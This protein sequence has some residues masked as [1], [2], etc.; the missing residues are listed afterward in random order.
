MVQT[1]VG[2][3]DV[4]KALTHRPSLMENC[5]QAQQGPLMPG[6]QPQ[7]GRSQQICGAQWHHDSAYAN[8]QMFVRQ[9]SR[10]APASGGYG[11]CGQ[12]IMKATAAPA[13]ALKLLHYPLPSA[14]I[15]LCK[16]PMS[17]RLVPSNCPVGV[18]SRISPLEKLAQSEPEHCFMIQTP[19]GSAAFDTMPST[20]LEDL[21]SNGQNVLW[22]PSNAAEAARHAP[23]G[24]YV[25][26]VYC[27]S[28][29]DV[30][31]LPLPTMRR[32]EITPG[33]Q[34]MHLMDPGLRPLQE[35]NR[36]PQVQGPASKYMAT[37]DMSSTD[38]CRSNESTSASGGSGQI[39]GSI[40]H[41]ALPKA[42]LG[43]PELPSRG[44]ALHAWKACKPCAFVFQE[45][46]ANNEECEFC[47]LCEPGERKRRK[48]ER[49][50]ERRDV[51]Q[52]AAGGLRNQQFTQLG[53][54]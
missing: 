23:S 37:Q 8:N 48:K 54:R 3:M 6:A 47:H 16:A 9:N 26:N 30:P 13:A 12:R 39:E 40:D 28:R 34:S 5:Y 44:S 18:L 51:R 33:Q 45:G 10:F 43:S 49:K 1:C 29:N 14:P 20:P 53:M 52:T 41:Q 4:S 11:Y 35:Y 7:L 25:A 2:P 38:P 27:S 21:A 19:T 36:H 46:C 15:G 50:N 17:C 42:E 24:H 32:Y 22:P 31:S